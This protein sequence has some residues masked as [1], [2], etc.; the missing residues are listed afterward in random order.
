MSAPSRAAKKAAEKALHALGKEELLYAHH[1]GVHA[2]PGAYARLAEFFEEYARK[3][4][5][6][7][8]GVA[9]EGDGR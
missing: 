6:D 8:S 5:P 7:T 9:G 3:N 2:R 4:A 1:M